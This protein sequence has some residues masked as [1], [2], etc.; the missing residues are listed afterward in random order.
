MNS[1]RV[2]VDPRGINEFVAPYELVKTMRASILVLGPL[3]ARFGQA[4]VSLPGGC[5]IGARP[6][7][8]H[9]AGL[10]AM[11]AEIHVENGYIRARAGRLKGARLVLDTVTVT[12]TENLMM[13][14]TLAEG[15]TVIDNA[16]REPEVVDL[17]QMLVAMGAQIQG[18]G[19][20]RI[21]I[22]GV[23]RLHGAQYTVQPDRIETGTF[24][25]AG[26]I[27]GGRVLA[28]HTTPEHLEAVLQKLQE[29]GAEIKT[30]ADWIE[31]D[32]HGR[33]AEVGGCPYRT[34]SRLPDRHA[35]AVRGAGLRGR[36][37]GHDHRNH[38]RE[39]L[40]APAGNAAPG[41]GDTPRGQYG[42]H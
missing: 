31:L 1:K 20:D 30:G 13:A 27:T 5:A 18:A 40:H 12:G 15:Q 32:M 34:L 26:A 9:V 39:P 3:L 11:G 21:V 25:V 7:N 16:A 29:A 10:T 24:L 38:L 2:A 22:D 6:V 17:A 41:R 8:I 4:D 14:A 36:W 23:P 37:R 19:T 35:G 42:H 33:A 28:R